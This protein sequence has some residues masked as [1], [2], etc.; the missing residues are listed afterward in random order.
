MS[1]EEKLCVRSIF[2]LTNVEIE[3][4]LVEFGLELRGHVCVCV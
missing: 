4:E 2:N 1:S 3:V